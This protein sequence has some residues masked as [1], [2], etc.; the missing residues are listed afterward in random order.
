MLRSLLIAAFLG[1]LLGPVGPVQ[2]LMVRTVTIGP[3]TGPAY[4]SVIEQGFRFVGDAPA[5]LAADEPDMTVSSL[6]PAATA[7]T[8]ADVPVTERR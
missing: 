6:E 4:Y 5:T 1:L 3:V 7:D 8:L 2:P